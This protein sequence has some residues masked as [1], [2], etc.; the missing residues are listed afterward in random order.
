MAQRRVSVVDLTTSASDS[1]TAP[2]PLPEDSRGKRERADSPSEADDMTGQKRPMV[3]L[4]IPTTALTNLS[5]VGDVSGES[6]MVVRVQEPRHLIVS[7]QDSSSSV[8]PSVQPV[9]QQATLPQLA[10][11]P[12]PQAKL[13]KSLVGFST[14]PAPAPRQPNASPGRRASARILATITAEVSQLEHSLQAEEDKVRSLT[15]EK[16]ELHERLGRMRESIRLAHQQRDEYSERCKQYKKSLSKEQKQGPEQNREFE[17]LK[18]ANR[19][20]CAELRAYLEREEPQI[21]DD[22]TEGRDTGGEVDDDG[23]DAVDESEEEDDVYSS[24]RR[25]SD[26]RS[27]RSLNKAT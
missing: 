19:V 8:Q 15:Q 17:A 18:E 1:D 3:R 25:R 23:P 16:R 13:A 4:R 21:V 6:R 26:G 7:A 10:T 9:S 12:S 11:A 22:R 5:E 24:R 14:S 20:L 2:P 27:R